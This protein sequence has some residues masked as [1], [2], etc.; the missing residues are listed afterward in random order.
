MSVERFLADAQG[1]TPRHKGQSSAAPAK[2]SVGDIRGAGSEKAAYLEKMYNEKK[3]RKVKSSSDG[4]N[5][6]S[7]GVRS[8]A[9]RRVGTDGTELPSLPAP[10]SAP[11]VQYDSSGSDSD[12]EGPRKK[13][14]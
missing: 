10:A 5:I 12:Y 3:R 1:E 8:E 6:N 14:A 4:N 11:I 2:R 13:N 9:E 7:V